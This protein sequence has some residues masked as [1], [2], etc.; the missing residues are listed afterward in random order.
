VLRRVFTFAL[1]VARSFRSHSVGV[2]KFEGLSWLNV[3]CEHY[4]NGLLIAGDPLLEV[5]L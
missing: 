3:N 5:L 2:S 4:V 1:S